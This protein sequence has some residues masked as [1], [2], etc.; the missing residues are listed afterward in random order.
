MKVTV[1]GA[2]Y[3]GSATTFPMSKNGVLVNLWGTWLDDEILERCSRE[4]HPRLK[5]I[6]PG[7]V[8]LFFSNRLKEAVHDV[9]M[10]IIGVA[11]DGFIPVFSRLLD[12]IRF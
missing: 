7:P 5:K 12:T 3:M 8:S 1:L 4:S 2:G 10:I 11:S 6:L 9:D